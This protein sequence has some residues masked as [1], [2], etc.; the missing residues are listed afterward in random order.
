MRDRLARTPTRPKFN[1]VRVWFEHTVFY[2]RSAKNESWILIFLLNE[3]ARSS[4][5]Q[6]F[7]LSENMIC[8]CKAAPLNA[9]LIMI[10]PTGQST[11]GIG[12]S[13]FTLLK[14]LKMSA[15]NCRETL[16]CSGML[17]AT[18]RSLW[19]KPG[20]RR[21]FL[22]ALPKVPTAGRCHGPIVSPG[23]PLG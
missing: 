23:M 21:E 18:E 16:S 6:I 20:P 10:P 11:H 19:K 8:R 15:R 7:S 4:A 17:F 2:M 3:Q 13:R 1:T 5:G 22:A 12:L 9:V 14:R